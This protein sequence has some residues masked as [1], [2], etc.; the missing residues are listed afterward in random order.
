MRQAFRVFDKDGNG[1]VDA[2]EVRHTMK[3][4]GIEL[5]D[6]DVSAMMKA[7][8]VE[9]DGRIYYEGVLCL[10]FLCKSI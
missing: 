5:S 4:L 2:K 7:A 8:G 6:Q 10:S 1:Y 3:E 9:E